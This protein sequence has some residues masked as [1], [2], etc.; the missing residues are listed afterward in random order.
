LQVI[1]L[2][3]PNEA[4]TDKNFNA[5]R[6]HIM[7]ALHYMK[8]NNEHYRDVQLSEENASHYPEDGIMDH[9]PTL[10]PNR[11]GIPAEQPSDVNKDSAR[12]EAS[13]ADAQMV[14]NTL[15]DS[16]Q[17]ALQG[18]QPDGQEQVSDPLNWPT[19]AEKPAS[20]F[21]TG[22][23]SKA[24]PDLFPDG[25][26]DIR[27]PW[28]ETANPSLKAYF[29]QLMQVSRY[30]PRH[31]S[32]VFVATNMERRHEALTLGNV[33][34]KRSTDGLTMAEL[35]ALVEAGDERLINKL[36]HFGSPIPGTH[37]YLSHK[38]DQALSFLKFVRITSDDKDMFTLFQTFSAADL[39]WHDLH[40]LMSGSETYLG[41]QVVTN[42][43]YSS[44]DQE[45]KAG[46]ISE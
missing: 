37:Q 14:A 42:D 29:K 15:L 10:D 41:K 38:A 25:G 8:I 20:E 17:L 30:F 1:V 13:T 12:V 46:C 31:H 9:L 45:E 16:I 27:M 21:V 7:E 23:F 34:A 44:L 2:K 28:P 35:K 11:L 24:F 32:F 40:R 36:I 3:N 22:F 43:V 39:H 6:L 18:N 19:R 33:F 4:I 26:G 5:N